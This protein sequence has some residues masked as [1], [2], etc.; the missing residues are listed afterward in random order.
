MYE[1]IGKK[2][3]RLRRRRNPDES[4]PRGHI[5]NGSHFQWVLEGQS[6]TNNLRSIPSFLTLF[7]TT[8]HN[9]AN[10]K[11]QNEA[12]PRDYHG[13]TSALVNM[14]CHLRKHVGQLCCWM[15]EIK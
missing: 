10:I 6:H 3:Y 5:F 12:I 4:S 8:N 14:Q 9:K 11:T 1:W 13:A 15:L 7:E 2:N